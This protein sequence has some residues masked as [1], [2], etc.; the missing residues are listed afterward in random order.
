MADA[1]VVARHRKRG[2]GYVSISPGKGGHTK[3]TTEAGASYLV[4]S[5]SIEPVDK[6]T[7]ELADILG[8]KKPSTRPSKPVANLPKHVPTADEIA[9]SL[10]T[11]A[12]ELMGVVDILRGKA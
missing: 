3:V 11:K 8:K 5:D 7:P 2:T 4:S 12:A 9:D 10:E 1:T 6:A